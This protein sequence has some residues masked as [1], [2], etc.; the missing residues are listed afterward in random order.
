VFAHWN[1]PTLYSFAPHTS[2]VVVVVIDVVVVVDVA[3]Q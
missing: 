1:C 2:G 3:S